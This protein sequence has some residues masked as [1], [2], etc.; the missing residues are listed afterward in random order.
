MSTTVAAINFWHIS[1]EARALAVRVQNFFLSSD[2]FDL[3]AS[4]TIESR[5]FKNLAYIYFVVVD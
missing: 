4:L 3:A 1:R 5:E 2:R